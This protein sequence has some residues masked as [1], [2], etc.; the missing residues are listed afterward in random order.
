M[1]PRDRLLFLIERVQNGG[2][3]L[4]VC[5]WSPGKFDQ[6]GKGK[7]VLGSGRVPRVESMVQ[8]ASLQENLNCFLQTK[9]SQPRG[10]M[11]TKSN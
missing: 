4:G 3:Q 1:G 10:K 7:I 6:G 8:D 5:Y 11:K 2:F 9:G